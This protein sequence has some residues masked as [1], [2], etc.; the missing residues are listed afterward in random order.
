MMVVVPQNMAVPSLG[1]LL[2][3]C[4]PFVFLE[5]KT[6]IL[7]AAGFLQTNNQQ[8][9]FLFLFCRVTKDGIPAQILKNVLKMQKM[10][11]N[12]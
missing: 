9:I 2:I 11:K 12:R 6:F 3:F 8:L 4:K 5:Q 10:G 7:A 1:I